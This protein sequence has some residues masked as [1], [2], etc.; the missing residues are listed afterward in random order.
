MPNANTAR[1]YEYEI[2]YIPK[3]QN[4]LMSFDGP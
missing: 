3:T 2:K 4:M 1:I